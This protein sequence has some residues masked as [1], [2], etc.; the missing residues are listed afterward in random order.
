[1][2]EFGFFLEGLQILK[3]CQKENNKFPFCSEHDIF[4]INGID[5]SK[6]DLETANKLLSLGF[7]VN[8]LWEDEEGY[9]SYFTDELNE[10]Y[11]EEGWKRIQDNEI[12]SF[13]FYV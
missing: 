13:V 1:M 8:E 4:Y 11:T 10:A 6:I 3:G 5:F 9:D 7:C 12:D 2:E